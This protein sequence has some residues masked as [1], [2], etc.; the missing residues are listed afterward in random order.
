MW[1]DSSVFFLR[2][3]PSGRGKPLAGRTTSYS[4]SLRLSSDK[5]KNKSIVSPA[6]LCGQLGEDDQVD[7]REFFDRR[8]R[9][10]GKGRKSKQLCSQILR[11]LDATLVDGECEI[12]ES[13]RVEDVQPTGGSAQ[14]LVLVS[15]DQPI[16]SVSDDTIYAVLAEHSGRLRTEVAASITRKR[17]PNLIFRVLPRPKLGNPSQ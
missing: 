10:S 4:V 12:L 13:L 7:P 2:R 5:K 14:L 1:A 6:D 16:E 17:T 9:S 8:T 11:T 15:S 3:E